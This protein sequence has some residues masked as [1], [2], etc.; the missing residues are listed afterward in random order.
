MQ[1]PSETLVQIEN[2]GAHVEA[3][4]T[5]EAVNEVTPIEVEN[6]VTLIERREELRK[7]H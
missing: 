1:C 4:A 7:K 2:N 5:V 3:I 6:K